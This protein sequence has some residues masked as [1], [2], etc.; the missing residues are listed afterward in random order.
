[1]LTIDELKLRL[2]RQREIRGR[3]VTSADGEEWIWVSLTRNQLTY[4]LGLV[5]CYGFIPD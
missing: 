3:L 2:R 5:T 1:M 4:Y